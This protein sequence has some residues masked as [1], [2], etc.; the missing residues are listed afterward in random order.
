MRPTRRLA[1]VGGL[2]VVL[3]LLAVVAAQ[4][5]FLGGAV[6]VGAWLLG[7][8]ARFARDLKRTVDALSVEQS[9]VR[10]DSQATDATPVTLVATLERPSPLSLS[11]DAGLPTGA[12]AEEPLSVTVESGE[13]VADRTVDVSWPV[14]GSHRFDEATV[15][16]TDGRFR[17][18]VSVGDRPEITVEAPTPRSIHVGTGGDRLP[19]AFGD[20]EADRTGSGLEPAELRE[21]APGD[22]VRRIDWKATARLGTPHV[23]EFEAETDRQTLLVVDHRATLSVGPPGRTKLDYLREV[24]LATVASARRADDPLA[25][26]AV[27]DGGVTDRQGIHSAAADHRTLR[28]RLLELEPTPVD[29]A[30]PGAHDAPRRTTAADVTRHLVAL[31]GDGDAFA[32]TLEPFL[33]ARRPYLDRI[34]SEPLYAAVRSAIARQR[35]FVWTA[36]FTDDARPAELRETVSLA[37]ANGNEVAVFLAPTVLYE[38]GGLADVDRAYDRYVD[39]ER[40]RR[41]LA[42]MDR[43]TALEVG[44]GDRLATVLEAGRSRSRGG[45]S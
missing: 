25:F 9:P 7:E 23:R 12:T 40:L 22:T 34:E 14:V 36:L 16:A 24:A 4:P 18:T 2:V 17:E 13:T 37:R 28:R 8:T 41:D 31:E 32:R 27:G 19:T 35:G 26:L 20:H 44:P 11:I 39:V 38:P 6:L 3:A 42:R 30:A 43:V 45:R 29:D 5:L 33:A 1:G 10:T 15:T 21:Y